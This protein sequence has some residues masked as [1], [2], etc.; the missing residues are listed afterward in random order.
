MKFDNFHQ[1]VFFLFL[2][3][4]IIIAVFF[5]HFFKSK[6]TLVKELLFKQLELTSYHFQTQSLKGASKTHL[7]L[8]LLEET[9]ELKVKNMFLFNSVSELDFFTENK[10]LEIPTPK[11]NQILLD[12]LKFQD[13]VRTLSYKQDSVTAVGLY[14]SSKK[15]GFVI[16]LDI[17]KNGFSWWHELEQIKYTVLFLLFV[18]FV[19]VHYL[20]KLYLQTKNF[21]YKEALKNLN[22]QKYL[23]HLSHEL[24]TPLNGILGFI[25]LILTTKVD[26]TQRQYLNQ[27]KS[28]SENLL[29][30]VNEV[31]DYSKLDSGKFVINKGSFVLEELFS[32]VYQLFFLGALQKGVDLLSDLDL[33]VYAVIESDKV[34]LRQILVNLIGN[35]IK[36]TNK[37]KIVISA[38]IKDENL[39]VVVSD[40]GIGIAK[41]QIL[42]IFEPYVQESTIP[43]SAFGGTGL[44]LSITK[45]LIE[46][47]SGKLS[48]HSEEGVGTQIKISLPVKVK[49]KNQISLEK[50]RPYALICESQNIAQHI[51]V[52]FINLGID[53]DLRKS[54]EDL[55]EKDYQSVWVHL[56]Q[57]SYN[58]CGMKTLGKQISELKRQYTCEIHLL[59]SFVLDDRKQLILLKSGLSSVEMLQFF[60]RDSLYNSLN[61][62]TKVDVENVQTPSDLHLKGR[63]L[64]VEDDMVSQFLMKEYFALLKVNYDLATDGDEALYLTQTIQYDCILLDFNLPKMS[65]IELTKKI[66]QKD[67]INSQSAIIGLTAT[68]GSKHKKEATDAGMA[69]VLNKPI[70]Y[71]KLVE[72]LA[73]YLE[74]IETLHSE[75]K[76]NFSEAEI[77]SLFVN[78]A[79]GL[80]EIIDHY[81]LEGSKGLKEMERGIESLDIDLLEK[82]LHKL[83]GASTPFEFHDFVSTCETM[84]ADLE[85]DRYQGLKA[86]LQNLK[87]LW[88]TIDK[89]LQN[90]IKET[91]KRFT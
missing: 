16:E 77:F 19:I 12:L 4:I 45:E 42:S 9:K 3:A 39:I 35:S 66:R 6:E 48:I 75:S 52:N 26:E 24:R 61:K 64:L 50:H 57:S 69:F 58:D 46:L 74:N 43:D 73:I 22:Q 85:N 36:F 41:D 65:G 82:R 33:S 11:R 86:N 8:E 30:I 90:K 49:K 76:T 87:K 70:R 88:K 91:E 10:K 72:S 28:S 31:L 89:D 17:S 38:Q 2:V 60:T 14:C 21:Y 59:S 63:V 7:Q 37:G 1:R 15:Q 18:F 67:N 51:K 34:R 47:M 71:E 13:D 20:W 84:E 32:E 68:I 44:G 27:A 53:I 23:A 83:K 54:F 80:K 78:D 5:L 79:Q 62:I 81:L 40:T 25:Q 29:N 55:P 56:S